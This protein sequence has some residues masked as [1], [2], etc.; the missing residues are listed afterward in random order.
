MTPIYTRTGDEGTTSLAGGRR[1]PKDDPRIEA[2]G[3]LDELNALLGVVR[4]E[5]LPEEADGILGLLQSQ[6]FVLGAE[7]AAPAGGKGQRIGPADIRRLEAEIDALTS[8]AAAQALHPARGRRR[9]ASFI[10]RGRCRQNGN[11]RRS[12]ARAPSAPISSA[13]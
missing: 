9:A 5:T 7:L 12:A 3:T 13:T 4:A 11:A 8:P 1:V 2:N 6:L 10:S